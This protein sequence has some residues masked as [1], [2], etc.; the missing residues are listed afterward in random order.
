[1]AVSFRT[2]RGSLAATARADGWA[3]DR[4]ETDGRAPED[5]RLAVGEP[6]EATDGEDDATW[7]S[8]PATVPCPRGCRK[9]KIAT[10]STTT[11]SAAMAAPA[12]RSCRRRRAN[13]RATRLSGAFS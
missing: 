7:V 5:D 13:W 8:L 4:A 6:V 2:T 12:A 9:A 3:T 10:T 11:P 1:M